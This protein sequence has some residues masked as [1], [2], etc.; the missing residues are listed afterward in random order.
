[1]SG[2]V[3]RWF[4]GKQCFRVPRPHGSADAVGIE[5]ALTHDGRSRLIGRRPA[6]Q[7]EFNTT[8]DIAG[9]MSHSRF[10]LRL[11]ETHV[12]QLPDFFRDVRGDHN[13]RLRETGRMQ[14]ILILLQ[15]SGRTWGT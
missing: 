5:A 12:H 10:A 15:L 9:G 8:A 7:D 6:D 13:R 1:M 2:L 4:G 3:E 11:R 14:G